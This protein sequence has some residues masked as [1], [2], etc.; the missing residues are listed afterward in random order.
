MPKWLNTLIIVAGGI[1]TAL[2]LLQFFGIDAGFLWKESQN[3]SGRFVFLLISV[4]VLIVGLYLKIRRSYI[5]PANVRSKVREWLDAFGYSYQV[6]H[7]EETVDWGF[8]VTLQNPLVFVARPKEHSDILVFTTT[9]CPNDH[10]TTRI[11]QCVV[12]P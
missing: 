12:R 6:V 8:G 11:I 3:M 4:I 5:T 10:G 7:G 9:F 2:G 1:A